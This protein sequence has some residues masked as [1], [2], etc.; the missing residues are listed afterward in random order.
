MVSLAVASLVTIVWYTTTGQ[1][2]NVTQIFQILSTALVFVI[3]MRIR[4]SEVKEG[5]HMLESK[6]LFVRFLAH[7]IRT[8][9]STASMGLD[10]FNLGFVGWEPASVDDP[11]SSSFMELQEYLAMVQESIRAVESIFDNLIEVDLHGQEKET[12]VLNFEATDAS[13]LLKSVMM[14]LQVHARRSEMDLRMT[15]SGGATPCNVNVDRRR[16]AQ[17]L[18]A[19]LATA[20]SATEK[21]GEVTVTVRPAADVTTPAG[22]SEGSTG[23]RRSSW[24]ARLTKS[25]KSTKS[26][27]SV[28][29]DSL[30]E[31]PTPSLQPSF[32]R[33]RT[34]SS[35]FNESDALAR[36]VVVEI[37]H[38]GLGFAPENATQVNHDTFT[39]NPNEIHGGGGV[40]GGTQSGLG[41][42]LAKLIVEAHGGKVFV[43]SKGVGRG[44]TF[45]LGLPIGAAAV[46]MSHAAEGIVEAVPARPSRPLDS[47]SLGPYVE[48]VG[49]PPAR[50]P[51]VAVAEEQGGDGTAALSTVPFA[52]APTSTVDAAAK[53]GTSDP[54]DRVDHAVPTKNDMLAVPAAAAAAAAAAADAAT[55]DRELFAPSPA[56]AAGVR[57]PPL[58]A[59]L[60][61]D[62]ADAADGDDAGVKAATV[63]Q[64]EGLYILVVEDAPVAR[65]MLVKLLK[66]M[67]CTADEAEDGQQA[68][69]KVRLCLYNELLSN[70]IPI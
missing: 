35:N 64:A 11:M 32:F 22:G 66:T 15:S 53:V 2:N 1:N 12:L 21:K 41:L 51:A 13:V 47:A 68:V 26:E 61:A 24:L 16:I 45:V 7:E 25:T 54:L 6:K 19:L 48:V 9:M 17:V 65:T 5:L 70:P 30:R 58:V 8:P 34:L 39:F 50:A 62:G 38:G 3:E 63:A 36:F 23:P 55:T 10:L 46:P 67:K 20:I 28:R 31:K 60:V 4:Q 29:V 69:G 44:S 57:L 43:T 14:P 59:P 37:N 56:P 18:R 52:N 27:S 49:G 33:T 40:G 42:Y